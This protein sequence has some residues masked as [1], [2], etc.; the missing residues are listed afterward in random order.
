MISVRLVAKNIENIKNMGVDYI[1]FSPNPKIRKRLNRIGL[2]EVGDISWPEHVGIFTIPVNVA[3]RYK[4]PL[5][6]WG[7]NSQHEYGG[8]AAA[9]GLKN[10]KQS[11]A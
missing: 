8:P 9:A 1:E 2:E 7:E 3:V 6:I 11:L 4:I 5:I 10:V